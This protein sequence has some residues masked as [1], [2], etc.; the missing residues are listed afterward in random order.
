MDMSPK[1]IVAIRGSPSRWLA[2]DAV[3][4][5]RCLGS[6]VSLWN[7]FN[8][9]TAPSL[10]V[11][12]PNILTVYYRSLLSQVSARDITFLGCSVFFPRCSLSNQYHYS[13][14]T[15]ARPER[16]PIRFRPFLQRCFVLFC[17]VFTSGGTS[18]KGRRNE[19]ADRPEQIQKSE[20]QKWSQNSP[21]YRIPDW[22]VGVFSYVVKIV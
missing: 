9:H 2:M 3:V 10:R 16:H 18:K 1:A 19:W 22:E 21:G 11:F 20:A 6:D 13:L 8:C 15:C 5:I 17:F 14:L 12:V 7:G 4:S